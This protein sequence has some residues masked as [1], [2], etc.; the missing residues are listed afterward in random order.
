MPRIE[1]LRD[2][3]FE[4][5]DGTL[6]LLQMAQRHG[7]PHIHACGGHA[8]CSTC[9]VMVHDGLTHCA[10]RTPEERALAQRKGFAENIRLACQTRVTGPVRVRRL[11][12]DDADMEVAAVAGATGR[13]A[14]LAILFSDVR[15]FTTFAQS[16]E[17][18]D[19]VHVM[20]RYF[21]RM[22]EAVLAHGGTL[23]TYMGDGLMALFGLRRARRRT[24]CADAVGAA[25][26][27]QQGVQELNIYLRRNF[28]THFRIGVGVHFGTVVVGRVGH[29]SKMRLTAVGDAV[30]T[31]AR[32]ETATKEHDAGIL[33]SE[34]VRE[35][36]DAHLC[37]GRVFACALRGKAGVFRLHEVV[38]RG[39]V[40]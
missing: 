12:L 36:L 3:S 16:Q 19:V 9:R 40:S 29:P 35:R 18:Y 11:V 32:I 6:T 25:L 31:A 24:A 30:N 13:E 15:G 39:A 14:D 34:P 8:R 20:N 23:D 37:T 33:V 38:A 28:H 4:E 21:A 1:Y 2:A 22:G 5:S 10:P 7:L 17:P 26:A 27:M